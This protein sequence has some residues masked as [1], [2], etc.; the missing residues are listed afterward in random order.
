MHTIDRA[1][2]SAPST[3][4]STRPQP[5][6]QLHE[7]SKRVS[8]GLLHNDHH[9]TYIHTYIIHTHITICLLAPRQDSAKQTTD[10]NSKR[11]RKES[12]SARG[13][14]LTEALLSSLSAH[15]EH[16]AVKER[17]A[18]SVHQLQS[19]ESRSTFKTLPL[20]PKYHIRNAYRRKHPSSPLILYRCAEQ[21]ESY[22]LKVIKREH[23]L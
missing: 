19:H 4:A 20:S 23:V 5:Y 12:S 9:D 22:T 13:T 21:R 10:N 6:L 2:W 17:E 11:Y 15:E 3:L 1:I 8:K 18:A 7:N 14:R 16:E